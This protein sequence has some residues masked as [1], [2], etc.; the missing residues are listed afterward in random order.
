MPVRRRK[1]KHRDFALTLDQRWHLELGGSNGP[2]FDSEAHMREAW[3]WHRASMLERYREHHAGKRPT[4][5]WWFDTDVDEPTGD[6]EADALLAMGEMEPD[7][8]E[9][10]RQNH[11][12]LPK[13]YWPRFMGGGNG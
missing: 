6:D 2:G 8:I 13:A 3:A 7:E 9:R 1:D 5:W 11:L 12:H 4:A 10:V